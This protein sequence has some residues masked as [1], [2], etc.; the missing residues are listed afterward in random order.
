[1]PKITVCGRIHLGPVCVNGGNKGQPICMS[2]GGNVT[3]KDRDTIQR[4]WNTVHMMLKQYKRD[5]A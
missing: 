1:M 2:C 3:H 4:M 5:N